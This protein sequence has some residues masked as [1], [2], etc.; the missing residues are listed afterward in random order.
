MND[1]WI[2][3]GSGWIVELIESQYINILIYISLW[4]SSHIKLPVEL[5]RPRKGLINIKNNDQK[6]FLWCHVRHTNP[7]EIDRERITREDK[8]LVNDLNYD[9]TEF[10][11]REKDFRKI[12]KK[13]NIWIKPSCR[14]PERREKINLS[15][16]FTILC[17]PLK[18]FIKALKTFIKPFEP[19]QINVKIKS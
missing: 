14:N 10:P 4:G 3:E 16:I 7:V 19:P 9:G 6:C 11:V 2:N 1:N 15:F 17:G 8:K 13:N 18:G 5:K 12:E